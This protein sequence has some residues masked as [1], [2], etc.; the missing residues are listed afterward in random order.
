MQQEKGI[1]KPPRVSFY[2]GSDEA[3]QAMAELKKYYAT[4]SMAMVA[5]RSLCDH[6]ATLREPKPEA[7]SQHVTYSRRVF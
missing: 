1:H 5:L 4:D 3:T 2:L 7:K 6:A